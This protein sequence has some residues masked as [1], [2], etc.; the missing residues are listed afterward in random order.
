[1][2]KKV[3]ALLALVLAT[4]M[5]ST[6][7]LA[8]PA[9]ASTFGLSCSSPTGAAAFSVTPLHTPIFYEDTGTG[10]NA[11][12]VGYKVATTGATGTLSVPTG[13]RLLSSNTSLLMTDSQ[14]GTYQTTYAL[15]EDI[16]DQAGTLSH[17]I[18]FTSAAGTVNCTY[19]FQ[20][21]MNAPANSA[22]TVND[23]SPANVTYDST[24]PVVYSGDQG[25]QISMTTSGTAFGVGSGNGSGGTLVS[26]SPTPKVSWDPSVDLRLTGVKWTVGGQSQAYRDQLWYVANS[27]SS[28]DYI[29]EYTFS[30]NVGA[31]TVWQ[32]APAVFAQDGAGT[33]HSSTG[34]ST[35]FS[36]I[37]RPN[38]DFYTAVNHSFIGLLQV[39]GGTGS[40]NWSIASGTLPNGLTL[41]PSGQISGKPTSLGSTA[42]VFNVVSAKSSKPTS[43]PVT[44]NVQ[45]AAITGNSPASGY[46]NV[47]YAATGFGLAGLNPQGSK[48]AFSGTLPRG[49]FFSNG[50]LSGTPLEMGSFN[51]SVTADGESDE[52]SGEGQSR[53]A[54]PAHASR[55]YHFEVR[56]KKSKE[57]KTVYGNPVE[58]QLGGD[59]GQGI[60][61]GDGEHTYGYVAIRKTWTTGEGAGSCSSD[62]TYTNDL[63]GVTP[64]GS[65]R[66]Y[67]YKAHLHSGFC[68]QADVFMKAPAAGHTLTASNAKLDFI[69]EDP[70]TRTKPSESSFPALAT[71]NVV[72]HLETKTS[73]VI[74]STHFEFSTAGGADCTGTGTT[75]TVQCNLGTL[76]LKNNTPRSDTHTWDLQKVLTVTLPVNTLKDSVNSYDKL[77]VRIQLQSQTRELNDNSGD[78]HDKFHG[79]SLRIAP[80]TTL[81]SLTTSTSRPAANVESKSKTP[82]VKPSVLAPSHRESDNFHH[83]DQDDENSGFCSIGGSADPSTSGLTPN[84]H[85]DSEENCSE[86]ATDTNNV[87]LFYVGNI[88]T[89]NYDSAGNG[90]VDGNTGQ[91]GVT[92]DIGSAVTAQP[93]DCYTFDYW[94]PDNSKSATRQDPIPDAETTYTAHFKGGCGGGGGGYV[95]PEPPKELPKELPPVTPNEPVVTPPPYTKVEAC[96]TSTFCPKISAKDAE[97]NFG[98]VLGNQARF[99]ASGGVVMYPSGLPDGYILAFPNTTIPEFKGKALFEPSTNN[100]GVIITSDSGWTGFL[101]IKGLMVPDN[102]KALRT[103]YGALKIAPSSTTAN[104]V[105]KPAA[106]PA[107]TS[108]FGGIIFTMDVQIFPDP[109]PKGTFANTADGKTLVKWDLSP[110][111][112]VVGYKAYYNRTLVCK[113]INPTCTI[114]KLIGPNS[115]LTVVALGNTGTRSVDMKPTFTGG[116]IFSP[117]LTVHFDTSKYVLKP[118][119]IKALNALVKYIKLEGFTQVSV[120]GHADVRSHQVNLVLSKNRA[121][122]VIAYLTPKLPGVKFFASAFADEKA[123]SKGKGNL[124]LALNRRSEIFVR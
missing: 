47:P 9:S 21:V 114:N 3:R 106:T 96:S 73:Y 99:V 103:A 13:S 122:V 32:F 113:V 92:G 30:V 34:A 8:I 108:G 10:L 74:P 80:S 88:G 110:T 41:S 63:T 46:L 6:V 11:E 31:A 76:T 65:S 59:H 39:A 33:T 95:L 4:A 38:A 69:F 104:A 18:S 83:H 78:G 79:S 61:S 67:P 93:A 112:T 82:V 119:D 109:S 16:G 57:Y 42:L 62:I 81:P 2:T 35:Q 40:Y 28:N 45:Q 105:T 120:A 17:D 97:A 118:A 94:S 43:I 124:S 36:V 26:L 60:T 50:V 90:Y 84:H 23:V 24:A 111:P 86:H 77:R 68:I 37:D 100:K 89:L 12:W 75:T 48:W 53:H 115:L 52:S 25:T 55:N 14:T 121:A 91:S 102:K 22:N 85:F 1:M 5:I 49:M 107:T 58:L 7:E 98:P 71:T 56:E 64:N 29:A 70:T 19:T 66:D 101:H 123:A 20:S 117:A 72:A 15:F 116:K 44:I 87:A 27:Q 51:F 54:A